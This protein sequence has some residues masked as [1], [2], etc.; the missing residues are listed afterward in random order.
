M[1]GICGIISTKQSEQNHSERAKKMNAAIHHRGPDESGFYSDQHCSLAMRRLAIIDLKHGQQPIFNEDKSICIFFNGEIYNYQEL[2]SDLIK[3]GH[4]FKTDSDTETILH[5]YE[6]KGKDTPT[7]L[8]GMFAF[9]VYHVKEQ[10]W[11]FARDRFGEKPFYY[12]QSANYFSFASEVGALLEDNKTPRYLNQDVLHYYISNTIVPEPQTLLKDIYS[13]PPSHW[14]F[15]Q[16]NEL[17]IE[18]YYSIDYREDE[19][20]KTE[21]DCV[22]YLRPILQTAIQRQMV[23]DVPLGAFLSGG[24]DSSTVVANMQKYSEKRVKTFTV[25]FDEATYDESTIAKEVAASLGTEHHEITVPN[26]DFSEEIFW[27]I[28]RHVG[29]PFPDS[30]AIPSYFVTREIRKYVTVALSGDGGD[31][32]FAGYPIYQWWGKIRRIQQLPKPLLA[33]SHS[34]LQLANRLPIEFIQNKTR[35]LKKAITSAQD[36]PNMIGQ[37]IHQLFS[38]EEIKEIL[39]IEASASFDS[40]AKFPSNS[41]SWSPLRKSM[42]YRLIHNLPLDMLTKVDRMSMSNSLEVRAPFLD[43]DLFEAS[44]KIP[45]KFLIKEGK[46]KYIIRKLMESELPDSVFN[47]P[48]TGFSIPLHKYQNETYFALANALFE[49]PSPLY[50]VLDKKVVLQLLEEVRD[51][52]VQTGKKSVYNSSHQLWSLMQLFAWVKY[53]KIQLA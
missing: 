47:H 9:C 25:K 27:K 20:L 53:F 11:F 22:T 17:H 12:Y 16:S 6:E 3:N 1:C 45:E 10:S 21:E 48:K 15:Y 40:L 2:R 23:S 14:A 28:I 42:Y 36:H 31:E 8:K 24:I 52:K 50:E 30:S 41:L 51:N 49:A 32:L 35:Q 29:L 4:R 44:T 37:R 38:R 34:G 18:K 5:L 13:L 39:K 19:K 26:E 33:A 43:V 7:F 46:G